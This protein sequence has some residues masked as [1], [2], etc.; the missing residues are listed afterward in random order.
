MLY[1]LGQYIVNVQSSKTS[2]RF[3]TIFI[4]GIC[5]RLPTDEATTLTSSTLILIL[6]LVAGKGSIGV[7]GGPN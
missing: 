6:V 4:F 3:S 1:T 7:G 2:N 5:A